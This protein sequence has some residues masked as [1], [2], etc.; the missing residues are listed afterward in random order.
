MSAVGCP[1]PG[2]E[3]EF[4]LLSTIEEMKILLEFHIEIQHTDWRKVGDGR[5]TKIT[6][7]NADAGD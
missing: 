6:E 4:P 7:G 1:I 3:E 5:F 2:C